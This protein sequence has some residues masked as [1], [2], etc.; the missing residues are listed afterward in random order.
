MK[1]KKFSR[2]LFLNKKTVANL[3][4][5][6]MGSAKGGASFYSD[7]TCDPETESCQTWCF[8]PVSLC[9]CPTNYP[10]TLCC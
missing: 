3:D 2:K 5:K 1:T 10:A 7:C 8:I 9:V 6:A 4:E